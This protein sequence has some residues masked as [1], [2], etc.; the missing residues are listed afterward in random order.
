MSQAFGAERLKHY[1]NRLNVDFPFAARW[2]LKIRGVTGQIEP[3]ILNDAQEYIHEQIERQKM[4]TGK[5]RAI[6]LKARQEGAPTYITGRYY[7]ETTHKSGKATFIL[8]HEASTTEKLFQMV[9]RYHKNV[10]K[11]VKML[12]DVENQ[13]RMVFSGLG[14]EYFVGTAGNEDVGRGGTVQYLHASE[15][16]FYQNGIGFK[17]GLLQSVPDV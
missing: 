17:T 16:A 2:T 13:R 9:S 6:I 5:V 15:A 11:S 14:S 10:P 8:S 7:W 1:H 12:S 3:F 4:A